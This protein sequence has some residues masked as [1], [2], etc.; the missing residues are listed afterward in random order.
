MIQHIQGH[1]QAAK[2]LLLLI[3]EQRDCSQWDFDN[4]LFELDRME[5][6]LQIEIDNEIAD[7][8]QDCLSVDSRSACNEYIESAGHALGEREMSE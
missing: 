7:D 1:A 8:Y 4:I 3:K 2:K 5:E 6:E